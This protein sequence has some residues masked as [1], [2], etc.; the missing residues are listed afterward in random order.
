M[1]GSVGADGRDAAVREVVQVENPVAM[2]EAWVASDV[3]ALFNESVFYPYTS[4][5]YH[6]LLAAAL[7]DNYRAGFGFEELF[8]AVEAGRAGDATPDGALVT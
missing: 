3:A 2:H 1:T 6:T 5:K 7:L 4:L 8:V